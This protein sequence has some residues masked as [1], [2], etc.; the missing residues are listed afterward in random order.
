MESYLNEALDAELDERDSLDENKINDIISSAQKVLDS[1]GK[2][3]NILEMKKSAR[4]LMREYKGCMPGC[5][6]SDTNPGVDKTLL[7]G[8]IDW[9]GWL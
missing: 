3:P 2:T 8:L 4:E 6:T 7:D 5:G 1:P 9:D